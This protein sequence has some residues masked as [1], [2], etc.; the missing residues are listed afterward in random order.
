MDQRGY[1]NPNA[2]LTEQQA[3]EIW[4][5]RRFGWRGYQVAEWFG[6]SEAQVS[7]ILNGRQWRHIH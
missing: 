3:R 5:L 6:I 7:R 1:R 2:R 4:S